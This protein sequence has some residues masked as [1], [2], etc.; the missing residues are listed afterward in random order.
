MSSLRWAPAIG[1]LAVLA[2]VPGVLADCSADHSGGEFTTQTTFAPA[3]PG[4]AVI[5]GLVAVPLVLVGAVVAAVR[6]PPVAA[7][8]AATGKWMCT[9]TQW[10]WV[11]DE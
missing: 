1:L 2:F 11:P 6:A 5:A 7:P 10:V 3:A 9:P 4:P 8:K